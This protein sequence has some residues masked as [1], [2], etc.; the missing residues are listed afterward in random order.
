MKRGWKSDV[1]SEVFVAHS[2]RRPDVLKSSVMR[3]DVLM[4]RSK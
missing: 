1:E 3:K 2:E 4:R